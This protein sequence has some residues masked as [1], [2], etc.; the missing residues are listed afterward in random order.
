VASSLSR[1]S[2]SVVKFKVIWNTPSR[3]YEGGGCEGKTSSFI[4]PETQ[5]R[6]VRAHA[7]AVQG[8]PRDPLWFVGVALASVTGGA[9]VSASVTQCRRAR[10]GWRDGPAC[11]SEWRVRGDGRMGRVMGSDCGPNS[12]LTFYFL[13]IFF[14]PKFYFNFKFKFKSCAKLSSKYIVKL[15]VSIL[16]I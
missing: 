7:R 3:G 1:T 11:Q 10:R 16:E 2:Q 15:K 12:T 9:H 4:F 8:L 5:S 13:S 6:G 14:I